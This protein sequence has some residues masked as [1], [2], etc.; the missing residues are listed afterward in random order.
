MTDC[1]TPAEMYW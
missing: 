1:L